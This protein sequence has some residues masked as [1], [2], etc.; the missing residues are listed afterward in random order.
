[1]AADEI[2]PNDFPLKLLQVRAS[3][4]GA[5]KSRA[6][7]NVLLPLGQSTSLANHLEDGSATCFF[8]QILSG[9]ILEDLRAI[10][11]AKALRALGCSHAPNHLRRKSVQD[12]ESSL[13]ILR[14]ASAQTG[15]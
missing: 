7:I 3:E 10:L 2:V 14:E 1:M 11:V 13:T 5:S 6:S 12:L 15:V 9:G 8:S 4:E